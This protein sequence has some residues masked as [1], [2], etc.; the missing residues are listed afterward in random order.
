[1]SAARGARQ[2]LLRLTMCVGWLLAAGSVLL[3]TPRTKRGLRAIER[4]RSL[5]ES[6]GA[7]LAILPDRGGGATSH[8][9]LQEVEYARDLGIPSLLLAEGSVQ[10]MP[11]SIRSDVVRLTPQPCEE[12]LLPLRQ[13]IHRLDEEWERPRAPHHVFFAAPLNA[14]MKERNRRVQQALECATRMPCIVGDDIRTGHVQGAIVHS[15]RKAFLVVAD[16]S[17]ENVNTGIEA[18]I[19]LGAGRCLHLVAAGPRRRPAFMFR[20]QQ[21]WYFDADTEL[22]GLAHRIGRPYRRRILNDEIRPR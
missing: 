8:G 4:V 14:D 3:E 12:E 16:I 6:C 7:F 11:R 1:M 17:G 10:E 20:D 22:V 21:V 13:G 9:I 19:A 18:G 5:I 2:K 15:I